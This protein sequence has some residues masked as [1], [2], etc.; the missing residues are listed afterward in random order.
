MEKVIKEGQTQVYA[1]GTID[2]QYGV[3]TN[4]PYL[5]MPP[6]Q[7]IDIVGVLFSQSG[8]TTLD[9]KNGK[10]VESGPMSDSQVL[11]I[12]V[13]MGT[14]QQLAMSA[15]NA[16]KGN[17]T[18]ITENNNKQKNHN[19]MKF[20]IAELHEN[21]MKS[22]EALKVMN[23]DNSRVSYSAKNALDILEE[24]LKVFP[25]RF[26][27]EETEV[28]SEEIENSVN[29]MLKFNIAKSLHSKLASSDWLNPIKELRSYITGAY[30]DTKWSFRVT[31]A[32]TRTQSQKGKMYEGLV[33]DLEGLLNESSDSIKSKFSAIAA[34]NPW[35][36][37]CKA[38][39]NEMKAE[40]NKATA[41]G[42]GTIST[43]LSPVLESENG[44]TFHL[45]GKNYN[46]DGKT[47]TEAEVKDPRF[48]DILEGLG[49]FKHTN[50]S[51]VTFGEGNN[52]T[53]EYNLS[54]G[55]I[56][57]GET[58]LSNASI[59]ELKESLM[60]INF[61][62]YRNQWKIDKVCKFFESV[63]LL[64][65]MDNF[66]NI[67]SNQYSNLTLTM[68]NLDEGVYVNKVNSAMHLNEMVFVSS[69]TETVKLV[70]EFINYDASPILSER[71]IAEN[72]EAA[73]I[74]KERSDISDK[75]SFL[76][77]KKAKVKEAINKLGE[78]EELTEAMNLLEEEI[79]KFEKSLQETYD[80]VV[81]GGNKGDKSKTH[82]GEDY[83]DEDEKDESAKNEKYDKVV[84]GGNK[85][86]K[87]KTHDGE[88][89][90]DDDEKDESVDEDRAEDIADEIKKKGEPK[91]LKV[92]SLTEKKSRNDYLNDG[93]VEA[94][95]NK[96]G[97]GL[98]K[99]M[100]VFVS[101]EDYTSLGDDDKLECVD[102]KT[103]K[104]TICPKGQLNVKI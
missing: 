11:A 93:F 102:P 5:N 34:K 92:K 96:S 10:V 36:M 52:K 62:G 83:E 29:P 24:S 58:D 54:E 104:T 30:E 26:K 41:N 51:L 70:K 85:G 75:I 17:Q 87:S 33:N 72:D 8:K 103:G 98:R 78:T 88:D 42:G 48:F 57:L 61:F 90:E 66:T 37:D 3:N 76:E 67:T 43:I 68:I 55:T 44:L 46:F 80:K 81:L 23:S 38:I 94:E 4:A 25:M 59:I 12:L 31:E 7:L 100:E 6:Q 35:S 2:R 9:G 64:A 13:G 49:M 74:E 50:E 39:L 82:D 28:I 15:I 47:I 69:A 71:L 65:E 45:H 91:K 95:I 22:I 14:P 97:N 21:V 101:A 1:D 32:I 89:Y 27:N 18:E 53:L 79:S 16:F 73:K 84:L 77:E 56:K 99:G 20:T 63:H 19:E 86:D 60:G 40:D